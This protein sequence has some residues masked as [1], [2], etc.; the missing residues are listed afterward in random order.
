M[1]VTQ[2]F[3]QKIDKI[4]ALI[5][6]ESNTEE[7]KINLLASLHLSLTTKIGT[8]PIEKATAESSKEV[9][10]SFISKIEADLPPEKVAELRK[11]ITE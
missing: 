10:E 9:L 1:N 7:L 5:D 8:V 2:S 4:L 6:P 3:L 11:I